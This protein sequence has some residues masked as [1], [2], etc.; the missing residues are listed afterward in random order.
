LFAN[1]TLMKSQ[2]QLDPGT[3]SLTNAHRKMVGQA[4]YVLNAGLTWKHPTADASATLLFNRI[5]ERITEAG[6]VPV[7]DVVEQPRNVLDGSVVFP[8][9]NGLSGRAD[10]KNLLDARYQ[11]TQGGVV[12]EGYRAGRV[13]SI[14]FSWKQ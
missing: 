3:G 7:P 2:I 13:F 9:F 6:E 11:I 5:G 4:P 8:L 1:A 12:R 10:F 14:G